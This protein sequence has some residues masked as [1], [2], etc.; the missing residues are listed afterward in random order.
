[1]QRSLSS[2]ARWAA[3][4]LLI[5]SP[6]VCISQAPLSAPD[7]TLVAASK[8]E[9][10]G[11]LADAEKIL[12]DAIEKSEQEPATNPWLSTYL[13]NLARLLERKEKGAEAVALMQRALEIDRGTLGPSSSRVVIDLSN[14]AMVFEQQHKYEESEQLLREALDAVRANP[15][16]DPLSAVLVLHNLAASY[17]R[18]QRWA[19][20]EALLLEG[21]TI[22]E[23]KP[24]RTANLCSSLRS[25][26]EDAYRKEGKTDEAELLLMETVRKS[27]GAGKKVA[28]VVNGL[29]LLAR[30]YEAEKNFGEAEAIYRRAIDSIEKSKEP[31]AAVFLPMELDRLA[32]LLDERGQKTEAERLYLRAIEMR[33]DAIDPKHQA[34]PS[35]GVTYGLLTLYRSQGRLQEMEPIF[36]RILGTQERLLGPRH[37]D[38]VLSLLTIGGVYVEQEKYFDARP[39]FE[40]AIDIQQQNLGP[41]HAGL[42]PALTSYASLLRKTKED[43]L[44]AGIE[45]RIE[46]IQKKP[47]S[48]RQPN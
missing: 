32:K 37:G 46:A 25:G 47:P 12:R 5:F 16:S 31:N 35:V 24:P 28:E 40:R 3:F 10:E 38:L 26:L 42:I 9:R 13:Q 17:A 18:T 27:E 36:Q 23:S 1:M 7:P 48:Q 34:P 45:A 6:C 22:C 14:L 4:A 43:E 44:A 15:R 11:R 2:S 19:G 29:N 39:L 20:A 8:A 33:L 21:M 41:D 30:K